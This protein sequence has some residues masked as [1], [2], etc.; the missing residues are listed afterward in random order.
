MRSIEFVTADG[1]L[2][3]VNENSYPDL[4]WGLRGGGG[5]FGI[6]TSLEFA[7][8]P[9]KEVFGG[10]VMYPVEQGKE[11]INAYLQWV[12]TVPETLTSTFRIMHFPPL[13]E[14]PPMV[15]AKPV[16]VIPPSSHPSQPHVTPLLPP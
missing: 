2:L 3:Q 13:P 15:R 5:N 10:Q 6:V 8:Y 11:V 9:V 4:F 14:V 1:R 16:F 12:K 7:L